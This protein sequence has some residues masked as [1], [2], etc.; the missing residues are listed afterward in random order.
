MI[1]S[2]TWFFMR[3]D[4]NRQVF[5]C[6]ALLFQVSSTGIIINNRDSTRW[7]SSSCWGVPKALNNNDHGTIVVGLPLSTAVQHDAGDQSK[8]VRNHADLSESATC[9]LSQRSRGAVCAE[10]IRYRCVPL[11]CSPYPW[12][13]LAP[14]SSRLLEARCCRGRCL[15]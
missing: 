5:S 13:V 11:P 14:P 4:R 9:R 2:T 7:E 15:L 6:C 8:Q 10:W 12:A 1:H 3:L